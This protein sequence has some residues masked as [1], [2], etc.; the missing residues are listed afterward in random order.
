MREIGSSRA[1]VMS[2]FKP[3]I[4]CL[5]AR[6]VFCKPI[7]ACL[8]ARSVFCKHWLTTYSELKQ[9]NGKNRADLR[10]FFLE[11]DEVKRSEHV[12][13]N[14]PSKGNLQTRPAS[15]NNANDKHS[16]I[17]TNKSQQTFKLAHDACAIHPKVQ[18]LDETKLF[19]K[20]V[21][22]RLILQRARV[23]IILNTVYSNL[24]LQTAFSINLH[25]NCKFDN[26]L[27]KNAVMNVFSLC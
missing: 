12:Q 21:T 27:N 7:I 10:Q 5:R 11:S 4:A 18:Q 13:N 16:N 9:E 24:A 2:P 6:S 25:E 19:H 15:I 26:M 8:R 1:P 17:N 20:R 23:M 22:Q 14:L 3:I